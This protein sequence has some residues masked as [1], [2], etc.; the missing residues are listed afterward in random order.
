MT[1]LQRWLV[2]GGSLIALAV[3][4]GVVALAVVCGHWNDV[5]TCSVSA[6][7]LDAKLERFCLY[8]ETHTPRT[9]VSTNHYVVVL[10]DSVTGR[11]IPLFGSHDMFQ[12]P[13]SMP[14]LRKVEGRTVTYAVGA[15]TVQVTIPTVTVLQAEDATENVTLG[16][17]VCKVR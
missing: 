1:A 3:V 2:L 7:R 8:T 16:N 6:R 13:S 12:E 17:G 10:D 15:S 9:L 5:Q 14:A 11:T 4:A